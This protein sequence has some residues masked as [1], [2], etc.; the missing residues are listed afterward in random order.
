MG[1]HSSAGR[2]PGVQMQLRPQNHLG[3]VGGGG[4]LV[5]YNCLSCDTTVMVTSSFHLYFC[6]S[7]FISFYFDIIYF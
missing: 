5:I 1:L 4:G 2:G 3:R 6:S 7:Q